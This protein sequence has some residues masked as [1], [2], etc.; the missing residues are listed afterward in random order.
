MFLFRR[1]VLALGLVT[2]GVALV[3]AQTV[4]LDALLRGGRIHYQGGRYERALEQFTKALELYGGTV[5]NS[6]QAEIHIWI[7]LCEA[8]LK[9]SKSAAEHII[10]ALENDSGFVNRTVR[11][12]TAQ[13]WL[14]TALLTASRDAYGAGNY[15]EA[16]KF[17]LAAIRIDPAKPAT[18]ALVA[19]AYSALGRFDEM[20]ATAWQMV[21]LDTASGEALSL[22]GLYFLEKP[23]SL[24]PDP[25]M[26]RQRWDSTLYYYR[27]AIDIYRQRWES[28]LKELKDTLRLADTARLNATA[29][30]LVENSRYRSLT[31]QRAYI[32]KELGMGK[33][34]MAVGQIAA[35]LFYAANNL[36]VAN[37]RAGSA[38]LRASSETRGDTAERY[39]AIAE[40]LF[41]D[42]LRYDP[43]D[44]AALFNLG[45][46]QY[47]GRKDSLAMVSFERVIAGAVVPLTELPE[48]FQ[49]RLLSQISPELAKAGYV[50]LTGPIV[51]ETDSIIFSLGRQGGGF[52]WFY[53][54][55][56]KG[57]SG[58]TAATRADA[59]EMFLSLENPVQLENLYLLLGVS[60]TGLAMSLRDAKRV[61]AAREFFNRAIGDLLMVTRLNP[62]NAEAYQNLTHCYRET[63]QKEK[64]EE[65]YKIYKQLSQ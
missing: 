27:R 55:E 38:M 36:N 2:V 21:R 22:I 33:R 56:L 1:T 24:W 14:F 59:K 35:R 11:D 51:R 28:G 23:D 48:V 32:E 3:S 6:K 30:K 49:D 4:P 29:K 40:Q 13:H 17:S 12:E 58:F 65:A 34:W 45:I 60:R 9:R 62:K 53:F 39:R 15:D 5:D 57:R 43:A 46:A 64:A 31:E 10:I 18:Y 63:G 25:V 47:Q 26:K 41:E 44:Y 37:S 42:A 7:G 20:L 50:E 61:D 54:P 8:Q 19:N 52:V 16:L